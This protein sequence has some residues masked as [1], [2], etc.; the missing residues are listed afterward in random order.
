MGRYEDGM[1]HL[2]FAR[3]FKKSDDY[4]RARVEYM[5]AVESF[6]Q[7]NAINELDRANIEYS[8]FVKIDPIF[9]NLTSVLIAIIEDNQ[10]ILQSEI[11]NKALEGEWSHIYNYNRPIMKDDIY[12]AL[13]FADKFGMINRKK[14]GRSYELFVNE[15]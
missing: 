7:A 5:K 3:D 2:N 8:E 11:V 10:G 4:L 15:G 9:Q 6:K 13:Y 12:Y 14:K 1:K